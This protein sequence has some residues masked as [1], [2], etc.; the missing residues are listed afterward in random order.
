[1]DVS[2]GLEHPTQNDDLHVPVV[3]GTLRNAALLHLISIIARIV[4]IVA[5]LQLILIIIARIVRTAALRLLLC[6]GGCTNV[7]RIAALLL[8]QQAAAQ[9]ADGPG[10][11]LT[12]HGLSIGQTGQQGPPFTTEKKYKLTKNMYHSS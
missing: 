6:F 12:L 8:L 3:V 9:Q 5:L 4:R 2:R 11:V 10:R 7:V 1:M